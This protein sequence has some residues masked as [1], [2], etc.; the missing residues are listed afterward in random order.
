MSEAT[1]D[2][3]RREKRRVASRLW[4]AANPER[5]KA[6][7]KAHY[8]ANKEKSCA[9][10]RA[11]YAANTERARAKHQAYNQANKDKNDAVTKA[12]RDANKD[13]VAAA[14]RAWRL[15]NAERDKASK[16]AYYQMHR[17][18]LVENSRRWQDANPDRHRATTKAYKQANKRKIAEGAK[19]KREANP[20]KIKA[21][22]LSYYQKD[23]EH[24]RAV[25]R[26]HSNRRNARKR[27][28]PNFAVSKKDVARLLRGPCA[29][30]F[31]DNKNIQIDHIIP[32]SRGGS[33]GI[34]NFQSLCGHHNSS[35]NSLFWFEYRAS[36]AT[37][38]TNDWVRHA[39]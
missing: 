5:N 30:P 4:K 22:R 38:R 7:R 12:W 15:A 8:E 26:L 23:I 27:N 1:T 13:M 6:G 36:L 35:K 14:D 9:D 29:V 37:R 28:L 33:H 31:C 16:Q 34:G 18:K 17:E 19:A 32:I 10:A 21:Q 2:E 11:W 3:L 20:E 24:S 39:T 25:G